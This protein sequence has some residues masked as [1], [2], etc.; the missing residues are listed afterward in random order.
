M[1]KLK[2]YKVVDVEDRELRSDDEIKNHI[3]FLD[4]MLWAVIAIL[5]LI[6]TYFITVQN[7]R[8][9]ILEEVVSRII[10]E[11]IEENEYYT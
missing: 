8:I 3:T 2:T 4:I 7:N 9:A 10:K 11:R 5:F 1:S 6:F